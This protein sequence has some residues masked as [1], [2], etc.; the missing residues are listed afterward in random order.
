MARKI[1]EFPW[2]FGSVCRR[3]GQMVPSAI[4]LLY[5]STRLNSRLHSARLYTYMYTV[6]PHP[7][8]VGPHPCTAGPH[9]CTVG[10]C[11][12]TV[13]PHP[14][15]VG[16]HPCTIRPHPCTVGP[17]PCTV[18]PPP[19]TVGPHPCPVDCTPALWTTPLQRSCTSFAYLLMIHPPLH[20]RAMPP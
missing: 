11:P 18:G 17:H 2:A 9:P 6:G 5:F 20:M 8:T 12:C 16:P 14:S 10:P 15:T 4:P 13:G 1:T 19:C 7:C 3:T